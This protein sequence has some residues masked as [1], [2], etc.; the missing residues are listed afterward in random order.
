[1]LIF[2]RFY[3]QEAISSQGIGAEQKKERSDAIFTECSAKIKPKR[4][5]K[6]R[7]KNTC[8]VKF[9]FMEHGAGWIEL[10]RLRKAKRWKILVGFNCLGKKKTQK[11]YK[12]QF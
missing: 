7:A 1:M 9:E 12:Y 8:N 2:K 4:I 5:K 3:H 11:Y 6:K 10:E